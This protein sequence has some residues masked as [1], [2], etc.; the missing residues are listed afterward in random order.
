MPTYEVSEDKCALTLNQKRTIKRGDTITCYSLESLQKIAKEW[1]KTHPDNKI[2]NYSKIKNSREELWKS[3]QNKLA[4]VCDN[5]EH[6]WKKQAFIKKMKDS[7]IEYYTFKREYPPEWKINKYT[8]LNTYD[9]LYV[10]KQF[11]KTIPSFKFL[12]VIPSDCPTKIT[13]ELT[14][15]NLSD[16]ITEGIRNIGVVY[17]LDTSRQNGSHWVGI[18]IKIYPRRKGIEK[19]FFEINYYDS[20]GSLPIALIKQFID[21]LVEKILADGGD[22]IVIYNNTRHQFGGSECG[23]YSMN[24]ILERLH[25]KTMY[26]I[27]RMRIPDQEMNYL[28]RILYLHEENGDGGE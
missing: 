6:C 25:G 18:F 3:I 14:K 26:E 27:S 5:D 2:K 4:N 23:M 13:C 8:W 16:F 1:N 9:I 28:R 7:E 19:N 24:F 17:N 10:M 22:Y 15:L 11:E 12:G 20:S 21:N